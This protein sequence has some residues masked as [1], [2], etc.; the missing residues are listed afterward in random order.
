MLENELRTLKPGARV[1]KQQPNSHVFF[2]DDSGAL[3]KEA[4]ST[5]DSLVKEYK[6]I[7]HT[8]RELKFQEESDAVC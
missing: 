1:Y 4:K 3:L 6:D 2:K 7:E 8:Q 5:L